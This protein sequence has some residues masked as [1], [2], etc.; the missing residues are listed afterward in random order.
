MT[1]LNPI[2]NLSP[3]PLFLSALLPLWTK[4]Q[5][6]LY[7]KSPPMKQGNP[8]KPSYIMSQCQ[9]HSHKQT[10]LDISNMPSSAV[11]IPLVNCGSPGMITA[12]S[13]CHLSDERGGHVQI[14]HNFTPTIKSLNTSRRGSWAILSIPC[15]YP[16][17]LHW[18]LVLL[19]HLKRQ[20]AMQLKYVKMRISFG[21][22]WTLT[23]YY[24]NRNQDKLPRGRG[25]GQL[26]IDKRCI[27]IRLSCKNNKS[28]L[29]HLGHEP[30]SQRSEPCAWTIHPSQ[31]FRNE[32]YISLYTTSSDF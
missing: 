16:A 32:D 3:Y 27:G 18:Y 7:L 15:A 17:S 14:V 11:V 13:I 8:S 24:P 29:T 20:Y 19:L 22:P 23:L 25:V 12:P 1:L 2:P 9:C 31:P 30:Y 26:T 28:T 4:L 5:G 21:G 10:L 6:V